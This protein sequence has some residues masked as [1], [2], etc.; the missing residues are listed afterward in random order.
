M[1][2][3]HAMRTRL[4]QSVL[5]IHQD[6]VPRYKKTGSVVRNSYFWALRSIADR[7]SFNQDWELTDEVWPALTRMLTSF[8]ASGYLGYS[9]T[10]L[11]FPD[12][13][14]IPAVLKPMAT[15]AAPNEDGA[16]E[17]AVTTPE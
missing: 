2:D 17:E 5:L 16:A 13:A 10:I 15:W 1:S 14:E 6:D 8:A 3:V 4:H 7:A 12:R 9:E 11:E